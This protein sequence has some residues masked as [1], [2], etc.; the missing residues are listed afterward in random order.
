MS[1]LQTARTPRNARKLSGNPNQEETTLISSL[2][3]SDP[4]NFEQALVLCGG[5]G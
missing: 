4:M 2:S 1:E 5:Y 3:P